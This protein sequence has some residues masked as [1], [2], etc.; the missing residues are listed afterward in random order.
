LS[1]NFEHQGDILYVERTNK[2][3]VLRFAK[4]GWGTVVGW[5]KVW[6]GVGTAYHPSF[7]SWSEPIRGLE[8][9]KDLPLFQGSL[10][11]NTRLKTCSLRV[12][13]SRFALL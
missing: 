2:S 3:I 9:N 5:E 1:Q 8:V 4:E 7:C 10:I 12:T 13:L 6:D 11:S